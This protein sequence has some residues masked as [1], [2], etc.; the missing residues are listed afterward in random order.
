[1]SLVEK[2]LLCLP[3]YII[4]NLITKHSDPTEYNW[5]ANSLTNNFWISK[6]QYDYDIIAP[7]S[8]TD[9]A[10]DVHIYITQFYF[11]TDGMN[12]KNFFED[13]FNLAIKDERV[14]VLQSLLSLKYIKYKQST[15]LKN[16]VINSKKSSLAFFLTLADSDLSE[17]LSI[18]VK[19][20]NT[21]IVK[22]LLN[23]CRIDTNEFNYTPLKLAV[24]NSN[25]EIVN[26]LLGCH[27]TNPNEV[28]EKVI[29][30]GNSHI[31]NLFINDYR[32]DINYKNQYSFHLALNKGAIGHACLIAQ[33][34]DFDASLGECE[35]IVI[36]IEKG[37]I[38]IVKILIESEFINYDSIEEELLII[39]IENNNLDIVLLLLDKNNTHNK[40]TSTQILITAIQ[41]ASTEIFYQLLKHPRIDPSINN[42]EIFIFACASD[43]YDIVNMLLNDKRV[44]PTDR[45]GNA[46]SVACA[47]N[48]FEIVKMLL[49]DDRIDP[50]INNNQAIKYAAR[51][52]SVESL[53]YL[54]G[55]GRADPS[56]DNNFL[57]R[58]C[59]SISDLLLVKVL[60]QDERVYKLIDN[61]ILFIAVSYNHTEV[62]EELLNCNKIDKLD[63]KMLD[64]AIN[65]KNEKL[66]QLLQNWS[67]KF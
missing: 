64:I 41:Y 3:S 7:I 47:Y 18:A 2:F 51:K 61:S 30:I 56:V 10:Q 62:A 32:I 26:L 19:T 22:I 65:N 53:L 28:L 1:M 46:L 38:D 42:N 15:G 44:N 48:K 39:T 25:I 67:N 23:D 40:F 12:T 43:R 27:D 54:L 63:N 52:F 55:D 5:I 60:M 45:K 29:E 49:A 11:L 34:E 13:I 9:K 35:S 58:F 14:D 8:L 31:L 17:L 37:Y 20:S 66:I 33:H 21:D 59:C 50:T 6:L 36:S 16:A 4:N 24:S 57:F